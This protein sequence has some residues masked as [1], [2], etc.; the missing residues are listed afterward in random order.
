MH[1]ALHQA[2]RNTF[3]TELYCF[4]MR[5]TIAKAAGSVLIAYLNSIFIIN[6]DLGIY[7]QTLGLWLGAW[8]PCEYLL[9]KMVVTPLTLQPRNFLRVPLLSN[10][11]GWAGENHTFEMQNHSNNR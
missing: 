8:V 5:V 10:E 9:M 7:T 6:G 4:Y 2:R 11:Q 1:I 3:Y